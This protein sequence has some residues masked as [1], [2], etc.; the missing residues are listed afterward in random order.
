[1]TASVA[2]TEDYLNPDQTF[3]DYRAATGWNPRAGDAR[4]TLH[5]FLA[6]LRKANYAHGERFSYKSPCSDLLGWV[7]ERAGRRPLAEM[8]SERIWKPM[9][10][11]SEAYVT[12]DPA[13]A[14]RAAGGFCVTIGDLARVGEM[15]RCRGVANGRQVI[16]GA[17]IDDIWNGGSA[18]HWVKGDLLN[19]L[20]RC[21]YRSKWYNHL[22]AGSLLGS[23]IHGQ[24]LVVDP[25]SD[26]VIAKH[27]SQ[28]EPS[29][30]I[31]DRLNLAAFDALSA[32][33][34]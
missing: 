23:G 12:V 34:G 11:A 3:L 24:W 6:T 26:L 25:K 7:L 14:P 22:E 31:M 17:W 18:E 8:F 27:S 10:A 20:A 2:F 33:L 29:G 13:G 30:E 15:V 16:P 5:G 21:R 1:M 19:F 32:A 28:P 9:G 4:Q